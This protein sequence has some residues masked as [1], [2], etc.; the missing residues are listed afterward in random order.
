MSFHGK[1]CVVSGAAGNLGRAV[2]QRMATEGAAMVLLDREAETLAAVSETLPRAPKQIVVDLLD[3][4][5]VAAALDTA[6]GELGPIDVV[7]AVAG[8]FAMGQAVHEAGPAAWQTMMDL[9]V[10]TL[11]PLVE[12]V[13]PEMI[14]RGRG[15]IVTV[16]AN[17]AHRG[18]AMM[19]PYCAA[20]ASVMRIT[21]SLSAELRDKGIAV[22]AVLPSIL[23][24]PENRAAMPDADPS[25][26]VSPSHLADVIAFLASSEAVDIHG[27]LLPV[28]GLS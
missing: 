13:V 22:N 19:G 12:A 18:L 1:V 11:L 26:W 25:D 10:G 8:G 3:R 9:N 6:R 28:T 5:E 14:A 17:A 4:G 20:K 15:R 16:G 7:C 23:D 24:T 2:A 27:A 21:E